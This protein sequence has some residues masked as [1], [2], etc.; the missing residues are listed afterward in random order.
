MNTKIDSAWCKK[1]NLL[2]GDKRLIG[3]LNHPH[4]IQK[5]L[6]RRDGPWKD[7]GD[8]RRIL[9]LA[10]TGV[11]SKAERREWLARV[12]E[13]ALGRVANPNPHSVDVLKALRAD[14]VSFR[15][16]LLAM[17]LSDDAQMRLTVFSS[18]EIPVTPTEAFAYSAATAA[19]WAAEDSFHSERH[20]IWGITNASHCAAIA[21]DP[22]HTILKYAYQT[23]EVCLKQADQS[24]GALLEYATQVKDALEIIND[25]SR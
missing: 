20:A 3:L 23:R 25:H 7:V 18:F 13:R 19:A 11:M 15:I 21:A 17:N 4:N 12:V 8:K 9:V 14:A 1:H 6:T 2:N 16:R 10:Q 5:I 24:H 22:S